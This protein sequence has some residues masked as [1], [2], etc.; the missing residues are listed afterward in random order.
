MTVCCNR[1]VTILY[2][3]VVLNVSNPAIIMKSVLPSKGQCACADV[4]CTSSHHLKFSSDSVNL[5]KFPGKNI[6]L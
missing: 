6:N 4:V 2:I 1:H 3:S 5:S